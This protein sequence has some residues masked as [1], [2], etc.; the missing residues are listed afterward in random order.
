MDDLIQGL[1]AVV[2]DILIDPIV[3]WWED[4]ALPE[5]DTD[6]NDPAGS[7]T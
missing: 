1:A 7:G 5:P 6:Q 3:D 2:A 4:L